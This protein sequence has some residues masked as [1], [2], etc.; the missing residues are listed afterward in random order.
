MN[1]LKKRNFYDVFQENGIFKN[2]EL[3]YDNEIMQKLFNNSLSSE[4]LDKIIMSK[5]KNYLIYDLDLSKSDLIELCYYANINEWLKTKELLTVEF[6]PLITEKITQVNTGLETIEH[7]QSG[8]N[9][10]T[11]K[12]STFDSETSQLDSEN[13][14][15][16]TNEFNRETNKNANTIT[17]KENNYVDN[18]EKSYNFNVNHNLIDFIC[19]SI[20]N[21]ILLT[22]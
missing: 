8:S 17:T 13:A 7:T 21:T 11:D 3:N 9:E 12:K 16:S 10:N 6:N 5:Y 18:I 22:M 2:I 4:I 19:N 15:N 14:S 20:K 1:E